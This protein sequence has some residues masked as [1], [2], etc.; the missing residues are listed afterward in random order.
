MHVCIYVCMYVCMCVYVCVYP[1]QWTSSMN[2]HSCV[3]KSARISLCA[4]Q[5]LVALAL[6]RH[7]DI[8]SSTQMRFLRLSVVLRHVVLISVPRDDLIRPA[9][10]GD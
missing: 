6:Q 9:V 2:A 5:R 8:L 7:L 4:V 3:L 10:H 1:K